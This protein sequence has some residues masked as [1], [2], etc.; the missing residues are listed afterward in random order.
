MCSIKSLFCAVILV[1]WAF[2]AHGQDSQ[3]MDTRAPAECRSNPTRACVF[4]HAVSLAEQSTSYRGSRF[5]A[6]HSIALAQD[7]LGLAGDARKTVA[8]IRDPRRR[9]QTLRTIKGARESRRRKAEHERGVELWPTVSEQLASGRIDQALKIAQ[10][11]KGVTAR[12]TAYVMIAVFHA[13]AGSLAEAFG[14]VRRIGPRQQYLAEQR[15]ASLWGPQETISANLRFAESQSN[16]TWRDVALSYVAISQAV[17]GDRVEAARTIDKVTGGSYWRANV[18]Q[19]IIAYHSQKGNAAET[20]FW[21][22]HV[23]D[24]IQKFQTYMGISGVRNKAG[25]RKAARDWALKARDELQRTAESPKTRNQMAHPWGGPLF[26]VN[27]LCDRLIRLGLFKEAFEAAEIHP[28]PSLIKLL[29]RTVANEKIKQGRYGE[30]LRTAQRIADAEERENFKAEL[31]AAIARHRT[32]AGGIAA[33]KG[34]AKTGKSGDSSDL[35]LGLLVDAKFKDGKITDALAIAKK[36]SKTGAP[37]RALVRRHAKAGNFAFALQLAEIIIDPSSRNVELTI[38][39]KAQTKA[40]HARAA[41]VT[42][43]KIKSPSPYRIYQAIA[44]SFPN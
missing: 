37:F 7:R 39:A 35:A 16:P 30:A 3:S 21:L 12:A 23:P 15:I 34:S 38:I 6:L 40:G 27:A 32:K 4:A 5:L 41:L 29:A 22:A 18:V 31:Q 24:G 28:E 8:R 20:V 19:R 9:A 26:Y 44:E 11:I 17:A 25:D 42:A 14:I 43:E 13:Q 10:S 36:M 33:G 1:L 2:L